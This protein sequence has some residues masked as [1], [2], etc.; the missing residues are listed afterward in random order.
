MAPAG[1][2]IA[3]TRIYNALVM[4]QHPDGRVPSLPGAR[5]AMAR[6]RAP[7]LRTDGPAPELPAPEWPGNKP[8]NQPLIPITTSKMEHTINEHTG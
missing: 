2:R 3:S 8:L 1:T 4:A 5:M 6:R 7:E